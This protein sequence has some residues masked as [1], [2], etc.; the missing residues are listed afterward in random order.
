MR[1]ILDS[2]RLRMPWAGH[3]IESFYKDISSDT[4]CLKPLKEIWSILNVQQMETLKLIFQHLKPGSVD[5][6]MHFLLLGQPS[7]LEQIVEDTVIFLACQNINCLEP[8]INNSDERIVENVVPVLSRIEGDMSLKYLIRLARHS[9]ASVRRMAIKAIG[10][11]RGIQ[12][13]AIFEF[14]DDPDASVRQVILTQM[15][16]SRNEIEED[17][18]IQY[19][20][21]RKFSAA[22]RDYI[23]E[24]FK[25]LGKCGSSRSV[26]FLSKTL[27]HRKWM[28]GLRKSAYRE[29]AALALVALKIPEARQVIEAAGR[30]LHPG[31]RRI[32]REAGR[33]YFPQSRGER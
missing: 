1:K 29:G 8:L 18:L 17:L 19:L 2:G 27:F 11:T 10:Q 30:S 23:I 33:E 31:L 25:T 9:S 20:Q 21:T 16:R 5:T 14:I 7:K 4:K 28:A 12:T 24:C 32:A 6:L 15:G 13:S 3:L 26:P 22:Q